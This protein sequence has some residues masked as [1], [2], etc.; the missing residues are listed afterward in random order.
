MS[1]PETREPS[2]VLQSIHQVQSMLQQQ[3]LGKPSSA[4]RT[5]SSLQEQVD[6]AVAPTAGSHALLGPLGAQPPRE[7][8]PDTAAQ[9]TG[10]TS[11]LLQS[12]VWPR[13]ING[14][15]NDHELASN[16]TLD[17]AHRHDGAQ[18]RVPRPWFIHHGTGCLQQ[19][20]LLPGMATT[21][22]AFAGASSTPIVDL[23]H[24]GLPQARA[25]SS[26][27]T[28]PNMHASGQR[29][30]ATYSAG[31]SGPMPA[32]AMFGHYNCST[33]LN[34]QPRYRGSPP[35]PTVPR[36]P[37][38]DQVQ[39]RALHAVLQQ[40]VS[41]TGRARCFTVDAAQ[42]LALAGISLDNDRHRLLK[43]CCMRSTQMGRVTM[44]CREPLRHLQLL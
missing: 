33:P 36:E 14:Q 17:A 6:A 18:E 43:V 30:P 35:S 8:G 9:F 11:S 28:V 41:L 34:W 37:M 12:G 4:T 31:A 16:A 21:V 1:V 24:P 22:G 3:L 5:G 20:V 23:Q 40:R 42:S 29:M 38:C 2:A 25:A 26:S 44:Q 19:G 7:G 15:G 32:R 27:H 39:L 13:N 10:T